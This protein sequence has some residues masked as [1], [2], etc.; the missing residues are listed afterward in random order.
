MHILNFHLYFLNSMKHVITLHFI[1]WKKTPNDAVTQKRQSQFTP[2]MKANAVPRL[3]SSLVWIDHYNEC[4]G[5]TRFMEFLR[6]LNNIEQKQLIRI[7]HYMGHESRRPNS[8]AGPHTICLVYLISPPHRTGQQHDCLVHDGLV[9][10]LPKTQFIKGRAP[11]WLSHPFCLWKTTKK[12]A[13]GKPGTSGA[14]SCTGQV[15]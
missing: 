10:C 4:N 9:A 14:N 2:K 5:I 1:S 8:L 12:Q 11:S 15:Y 6:Y 3:L 7:I 13:E